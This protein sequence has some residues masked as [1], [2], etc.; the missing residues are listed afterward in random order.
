MVVLRAHPAC[1]WS[2]GVYRFAL[3]AGAMLGYAWYGFV[4]A[5]HDGLDMI[6]QAI[7]RLLALE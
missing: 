6:G 7:F 3:A 2:I 4:Q 1:V 5:P